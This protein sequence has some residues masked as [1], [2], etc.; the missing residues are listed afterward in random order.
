M[1]NVIAPVYKHAALFAIVAVLGGMASA[2]TITDPEAFV[3]DVYRRL[4]AGEARGARSYIPPEDIYTPR[5]SRL[6]AEDRKRAGKEVGCID[7]LFWINGQDS[8]LQDI[9]VARQPGPD[10]DHLIVVAK[11]KNETPQEL[12]FQFQ[13][14]KGKW[15]LDEVES[16]GDE[17]WV[18]SKL[19]H[20]W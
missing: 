19:L 6:F 8:D 1:S 2:T 4:K 12:H 11:F 20:C 17:K 13:R 10:E 3:K 18:L 14:I 9:R 15:L 5:L 16:L 7:F